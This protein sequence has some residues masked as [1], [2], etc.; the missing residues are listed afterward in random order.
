MK[1][2]SY[3]LKNIFCQTVFVTGDFP[4]KMYRFN[5]KRVPTRNQIIKRLEA[6]KDWDVNCDV[7]MGNGDWA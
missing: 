5:Y 4:V 7:H 6:R 2:L 1:N 3:R